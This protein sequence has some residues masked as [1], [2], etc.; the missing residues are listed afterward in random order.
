[1]IGNQ[2]RENLYHRTYVYEGIL[3]AVSLLND[4]MKT[5]VDLGLFDRVNFKVLGS[6]VWL[7][8]WL[9]FMAYQ[10]LYVI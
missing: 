2:G 1:M 10:P 5:L 3:S 7:F 9:G 6:D 4:L 8:G